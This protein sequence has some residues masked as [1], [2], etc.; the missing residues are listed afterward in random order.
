MLRRLLQKAV[1]TQHVSALH[2]RAPDIYAVQLSLPPDIRGVPDIRWSD[3][4][5]YLSWPIVDV[6]AAEVAN[7]SAAGSTDNR[8][9]SERAAEVL[10]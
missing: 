10:E 8:D 3:N 7:P 6:R 2:I 5:I 4:S 1:S 9:G